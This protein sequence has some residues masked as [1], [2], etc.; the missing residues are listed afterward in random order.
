MKNKVLLEL[1]NDLINLEKD[2]DSEVRISILQEMDANNI[3]L[4]N[5]K[6]SVINSLKYFQKKVRGPEIAKNISYQ[7]KV[8][9]AKW[10]QIYAIKQLLIMDSEKCDITPVM[11][12]LWE[13]FHRKEYLKQYT[14]TISEIMMGGKERAFLKKKMKELNEMRH[15][16][17]NI[18]LETLRTWWFE[19]KQEFV[20]MKNTQVY[21]LAIQ[22]PR[23]IIPE[24]DFSPKT[25]KKWIGMFK[26][27]FK[28]QKT[29]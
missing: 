11:E 29:Q 12:E 16:D 18:A 26:T 22:R 4:P 15:L 19:H 20:G 17:R 13:V 5:K 8:D 3:L 10:T 2:I 23:P 24:D 28:T 1:V 27:E 21:Q 9:L 25:I 14:K 6:M 7:T